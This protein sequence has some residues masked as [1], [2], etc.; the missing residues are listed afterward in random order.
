PILAQSKTFISGTITDATT[1]EPLIG[2]NIMVK[3][4]VVGTITN[5][6][7]W[8]TLETNESPPFTLVVSMV[9]YR[10]QEVS[11]TQTNTQGLQIQMS[12]Q[13]MLGQEVVVSASRYQ[14]NILQ[15]P[16]TIEKLDL[17]GIQQAA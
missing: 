1:N 14:E 13:T 6:E 2:V 15:S 16:V 3:G 8:F 17:I 11:I 10:P 12:E 5:Y 9:G 4:K 7:G